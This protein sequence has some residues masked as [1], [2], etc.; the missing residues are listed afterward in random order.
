VQGHRRA[1]M[2][3]SVPPE[4]AI[5]RYLRRTSA[6]KGGRRK[7]SLGRIAD[8]LDVL[9]NERLP[10]QTKLGALLDIWRKKR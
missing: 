1:G 8:L 7:L 4:Q 5:G 10:L 3:G 6:R 9:T 2:P